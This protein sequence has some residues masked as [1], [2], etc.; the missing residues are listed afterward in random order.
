MN[1]FSFFI[2]I[3]IL[4]V[5]FLLYKKYY[6]NKKLFY[7]S[8]FFIIMYSILAIVIFYNNISNGF[9]TGIL[10]GDIQNNHFCDEYKYNIDSQILFD[11]FKNGEFNQWI[12][13][14]L[15]V[16]EFI[17][18]QGHP[19]Y[20]NYNIFVIM[21]TFLRLIGINSALNFILIKL[22]I[23]VPTYI[24]LYKLFK[25]YL[26]EK[27]SLLSVIIFSFLP[28]YILTNTLLMRDNIILFL[29]I[30]ALYCLLSK[31]YNLKILIPSLILLLF[32]RSYLIL[33]LIAILVFTFK[34][35]KNLISV[36]DIFYLVVIVGTIYFFTNYNF[37]VEQSN[38]FFSF[39]QI[40]HLQEN[41]INWYG[42][43][44]PMLIKL[45]F[46]TLLQLVFNPLFIS[47][48]SSG[49]VYLILTSLG[50]ISGII[51]AVCFGIMFVI[52]CLRKQNSAIR[53]LVK[54]TFYFTL[55]TALVLMAKDSYIINRLELMWTPLFLIIIL[56]PFNKKVC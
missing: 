48:L 15:P 17:D 50:N 16:F 40:Q 6:I 52:V 38:V 8:N 11:H 3:A 4:L 22:F 20:G 7:I 39:A 13:K 2:I 51:I 32:F 37:T 42:V 44:A 33:I 1:V 24:Y 19:S 5:N 27:L 23:Y 49:L 9:S 53:Y 41:F 12:N 31:E 45:A 14:Q 35:T 43:G 54:F 36:L 18:P 25:I 47:F 34:N 28:G 10:F 55:L 21:L 26:N 30:V 46:Q 29:L 56:L